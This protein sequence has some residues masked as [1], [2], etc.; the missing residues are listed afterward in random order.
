MTDAAS[1]SIATPVGGIDRA[2]HTRKRYAAERRFRMY[3]VIAISVAILAVVTLL[4]SVLQ[5][6]L[7]AFSYLRQGRAVSLSYY[8][9]PEE[10]LDDPRA[11]RPWAEL[12]YAAAR[13]SQTSSSGR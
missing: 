3:G 13:R 2:A 6:G 1:A 10:A 8:P 7:P 12:A 9:A 5:R 11:M 4:A